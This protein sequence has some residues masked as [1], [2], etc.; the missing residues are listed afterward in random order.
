M[1]HMDLVVLDSGDHLT[2]LVVEEV[3]VPL[4]VDIV[5]TDRVQCLVNQCLS[6]LDKVV[7][8]VVLDL[9]DLVIEVLHI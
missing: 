1:D 7:N 3:E 4:A 6:I 2:S 9:E 8:R 5:E